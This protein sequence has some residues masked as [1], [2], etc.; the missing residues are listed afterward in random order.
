MG[1]TLKM[2]AWGMPL[3][4]NV[5][6]FNTYA[7]VI[8]QFRCVHPKNQ[9]NIFD[10]NIFMNQNKCLLHMT[11]SDRHGALQVQFVT[12]VKLICYFVL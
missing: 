6:S 9:T 1:L 10:L 7:V 8:S 11:W 2:F 12:R 3:H 5:F 4:P